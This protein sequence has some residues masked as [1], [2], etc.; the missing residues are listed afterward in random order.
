MGDKNLSVADYL[1]RGILIGGSFGVI[2]GWLFTDFRR[3]LFLGMLCG[4]LAGLTYA[5]RRKR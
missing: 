5:A 2:G 4:A 1:T 3:G